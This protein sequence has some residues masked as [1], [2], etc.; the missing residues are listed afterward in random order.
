LIEHVKPLTFIL[1][2]LAGNPDM[3]KATAKTWQNVGNELNRLGKHYAGAVTAGTGNWQGEGGDN[4][5]ERTAKR[6]V[7]GLLAAGQLANAMSIVVATAGE[8]VNLTRTLVRDI[9]ADLVAQAIKAGLKRLGLVLPTDMLAEI[10]KKVKWGKQAFDFMLTL[11]Q[12][13]GGHVPKLIECY[14]SIAATIPHLNGV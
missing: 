1:N 12:A 4:Y 3:I 2:S 13:I 5:R 10:A 7:D 6:T 8:L 11:V 14:K 9:I